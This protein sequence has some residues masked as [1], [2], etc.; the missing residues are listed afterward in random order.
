MKA[1]KQTKPEEATEFFETMPMTANHFVY[2]DDVTEDSKTQYSHSDIHQEIKTT[3]IITLVL[4]AITAVALG[5][6]IWRG[7]S[8]VKGSMNQVSDMRLEL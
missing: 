3:A 4:V 6:L 2:R 7:L 8:T 1:P 5:L